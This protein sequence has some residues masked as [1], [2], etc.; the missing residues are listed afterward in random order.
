MEQDESSV[1][2]FRIN[3]APVR[4]LHL[5]HLRLM[6]MPYHNDHGIWLPP[7]LLSPT[8]PVDR[9]SSL[10]GVYDSHVPI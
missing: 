2:S 1:E 10:P 5:R 8:V 7:Q 9:R 3:R 4:D 6:V